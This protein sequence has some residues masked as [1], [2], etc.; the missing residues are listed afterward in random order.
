[1]QTREGIGHDAERSDAPVPPTAG[2]G[3]SIIE[4]RDLHKTFEPRRRFFWGDRALVRAVDGV[5]LR[6]RRGETLAIVGESGCGKSTLA[7]AMLRLEE[8]TSGEVSFE[9]CNLLELGPR[10]LRK[11]RRNFQMVYQDPYSSLN[12]RM[13]IGHMLAEALLVHGICDRSQVRNEVTR[14]LE[15][16]EMPA[17]IASRYPAHLSG[18]QR[19]R[20]G[21]ARAIAVHP[22]LIVAD[23][24]V[25]ALDVSV[26]AQILNLMNDL[27]REVDV[28]WVFIGHNLGV[29]RQLSDRVAVMYLGRIVEEAPSRILFSQPLHPYTRAL[30]EA[31]PQPD[32]ARPMVTPLVRGDPPAA[33]N[34]PAGCRFHPRC[35]I[36]RSFCRVHDP[37]LQGAGDDHRVACW[38]V[39]SPLLWSSE[40]APAAAEE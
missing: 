25:S 6:V 21:I 31:V 24:P 2:N 16:V 30:V 39:T 10:E 9:G 19:Q 36:A 32:P 22:R 12:P 38:A 20:I 37:A 15:L 13:K 11:M 28:T 23:E 7:R 8:P 4:V 34:I 33:T 40:D 18:G 29:V 17:A 27:K 35:P 26:Q 5:S 3:T 1:M 14:L